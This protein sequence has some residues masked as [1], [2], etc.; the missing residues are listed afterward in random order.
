MRLADDAGAE[1]IKEGI[2]RLFHLEDDSGRQTG[3]TGNE[4]TVMRPTPASVVTRTGVYH[5]AER[6]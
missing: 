3:M 4:D 1:D 5:Q 6:S 2:E